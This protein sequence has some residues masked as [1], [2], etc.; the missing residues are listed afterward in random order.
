MFVKVQ[1]KSLAEEDVTGL[2]SS[3]LAI[4]ME[5]SKSVIKNL[6]EGLQNEGEDENIK[7]MMYV[8]LNAYKSLLARSLCKSWHLKSTNK[9]T[10]EKTN[11]EFVSFIK[12]EATNL[13][14][15]DEFTKLA[16]AF[17]AE[18]KERRDMSRMIP[19]TKAMKHTK[20]VYKELAW[21]QVGEAQA[22][23]EEQMGWLRKSDMDAMTSTVS[24]RLKGL[25]EN[26]TLED[27]KAEI[28]KELQLL[29]EKR[30]QKEPEKET[31]EDQSD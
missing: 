7:K 20:E 25:L 2:I 30:H 24:E 14:L 23:I 10:E 15:D 31:T 27:I 5:K 1:D 26:L 19:Y 4:F 8:P 12:E 13:T 29:Y 18:M 11:E 21:H 6:L 16:Q 22:P 17:F 3:L 28:N 9:T